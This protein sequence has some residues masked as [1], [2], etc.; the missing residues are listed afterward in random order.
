MMCSTCVFKPHSGC[1][2]FPD[3]LVTFV[4]NLPCLIDSCTRPVFVR[5]WILD[6]TCSL[7]VLMLGSDTYSWIKGP[8]LR[9]LGFGPGFLLSLHLGPLV[10]KCLGAMEHDNPVSCYSDVTVVVGLNL[11]CLLQ[12][13]LTHATNTK[14]PLLSIMSLESY[15]FSQNALGKRAINCI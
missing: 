4:Y 6:F 10:P 2:S 13:I 9:T 11:L 14:S 7:P 15:P 1:P 5:L 12:Y 8:V 3:C